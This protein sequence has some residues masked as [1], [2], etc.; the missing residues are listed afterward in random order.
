MTRTSAGAASEADNVIDF[1][2]P[3]QGA[4]KKFDFREFFENGVL[5]LHIVGPDGI[6]LHA[7]RAE[8]ALLGYSTD[9]LSAGTS[10]SFIVIPRWPKKFCAA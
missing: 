7:N 1:G 3:L 2:A 6:I 8:L 5:P 10:A 4:A 9:D